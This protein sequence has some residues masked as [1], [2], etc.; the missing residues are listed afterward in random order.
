MSNDIK[1]LSDTDKSLLQLYA[2]S[3]R[4][5]DGWADCSKQIYTLLSKFVRA[6]LVEIEPIGEAGRMRLTS[7]GNDLLNAMA[8]L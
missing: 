8:Y 6:D 1:K 5:A 2:R 7:L 4:D 3:K